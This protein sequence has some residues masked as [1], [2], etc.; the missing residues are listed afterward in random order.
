MNKRRPIIDFHT[1]LMT[2][3][4][5]EKICPEEQRTPFFRYIVPAIEPVAH[6]TE[7][8]HDRFL[9]YLAMNF[10]DGTS[11]FLYSRLGPLFLMEA[12][13]LFKTH[14]LERM[15]ANMDEHGIEHSVIYSL[16]PLT[17]T[18]EL[19]DL[20]RP[21][22]DRLSIFGS[23]HADHHD[24]AGY[25]APL[26][27]SGDIKGI[28]IHPQV[29][30]YH[31]GNLL[32]KTK[33]F[34]ALASEF[35]IPVVIHTGH[36]PIEGICGLHDSCTVQALEPLIKAHPHCQ[37]VLNHL[38]W[39]SWRKA[40]AVAR[41]HENVLVETSWQPARIMRRAVDAL[42]ADR[43]IFGSDFPMFQQWQAL[44]EVEKALTEK[45]FALVASG[46]ARKLLK[47]SSTKD[48]SQSV[49]S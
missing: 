30:G 31:A 49:A 20:T 12:L 22:A 40:I 32:D 44:R 4:G 28:K 34:V 19:I 17:D 7:P 27:E 45:E 11:R 2:Q 10:R 5:L 35:N 29:G 25:L 39:E 43:V 41:R 37:F 23:V 26:I 6:L 3:P 42:G 14:G 15:I 36:I 46:N 1:H 47:L 8:V 33:D 9:R 24:P 18:R 21:Y 48:V 13:R 38:G 16:E